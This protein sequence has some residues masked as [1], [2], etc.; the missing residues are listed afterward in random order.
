MSLSDQYW[1]RPKDSKITW[2]DINFF[3]N[4]FQLVDKTTST[5]FSTGTKAHAHPNNTSDGN[6]T[7]EWFVRDG[8]RMLRKGGYWN[9]QEPYNEVLA[10]EL[11]KRLLSEHDYVR[12]HLEVDTSG[13]VSV[14]ANFLTDVEEYVPAM[15]VMQAFEQDASTNDFNHYIRCCAQLGVKDARSALER[16]IV[17]DDILA[18]SDRHF[19]NFGIVRNVETLECRPAP[20]FDSGTS[21]WCDVDISNLEKGDFSYISKQFEPSSSRQMLL[22]ED[23]SW[24]DS[25]KLEGFV[26]TALS[27]LAQNQHLEARLPYLRRGLE[28]RIS[29]MIDIAEWS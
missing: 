14:C 15:Y 11:H 6:L 25:N 24:F 10:T 9:N 3:N 23:M 17:C 19:R 22:I 2:E 8:V 21:L 26:D 18:N 1:V 13:P 5:F 12:Y 28:R 16:L 4:E 7:K 20:I 29:R 27:I